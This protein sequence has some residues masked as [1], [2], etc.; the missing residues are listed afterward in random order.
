MTLKR[1]YRGYIISKIISAS[2]KRGRRSKCVFYCVYDQSGK[3][4]VSLSDTKLS[5]VKSNIDN[6]FLKKL[7]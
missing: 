1:N 7:P 4:D 2:Y 3:Y 6:Q 5:E